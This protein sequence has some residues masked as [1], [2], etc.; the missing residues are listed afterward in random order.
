MNN[1]SICV[2]PTNRVGS[3]CLLSSECPSDV[4]RNNGQC[5]LIDDNVGTNNYI[6]ICT[7]EYYGSTCEYLKRKLSISFNN[8]PIP[9]YIQLYIST[10]SNT[11]EPSTTIMLKK[12]LQNQRT[13]SFYTSKPFHLVFIKAINDYYLGSI[14]QFS[15]YNLSTSISSK[16]RCQSIHELFNSTILNL[17]LI[18][19][20]KYYPLLCYNRTDNLRCFY[21]ETYMCLCTSES[22]PNCFHFDHQTTLTCKQNGYCKNNALCLQDDPTCPSNTICIC[23]D[24]YF[25]TQCQFYAKGFG[26]TLDDIL[27]YEIRPHLSFFQQPLSVTITAA[28]T[29]LM[30]L[31]GLTNSIL[32]CLTFSRKNCRTVGSG[33]YLYASSIT[34]ILTIIILTF[35]FCF[36]ILSQ[37]HIITDRITLLIA[38]V[39]IEPLLKIFLFTDTWLNACVAIERGYTVYKGVRFNKQSSKQLAKHMICIVPSLIILSIIH[40][41]LYCDLFDDEEE[42]RI[43][44]VTNYSSVL[45]D[46]NSTILLIH[47][48]IPFIINLSS[49]L[50]I[51]INV[52]GQHTKSRTQQTY[53]KHLR[54]QFNEHKHILISP[55][56]LVILSLPRLIISLISS[57]IKSSRNPWLYLCGYLISFI[58][59]ILIFVVFVIPS[60]LYITEFKKTIKLSK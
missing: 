29:I 56:I 53:S 46:Y 17:P 32:A 9:S 52:T 30:L 8:M 2:C 28:A 6:C 12:V 14:Q 44:C 33:L 31:L 3:R 23:T 43:W 5:V 54:K 57:C 38:C 50:F 19:R 11:S 37:L 20:V 16:Q 51:I 45:Q 26:L 60:K 27:R 13:L 18:R 39:S 1:Q 40:E 35:K 41:P 58:P 7:E 49:A 21:D 4:C 24:C 36:L 59:S 55:L 34:S 10:V 22:Y 47:F 25:G 48:L 15:I 42:H